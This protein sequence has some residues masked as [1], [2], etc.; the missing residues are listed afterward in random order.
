MKRPLLPVLLS[1]LVFPGAGQLYL[2]RV[3]RALLFIVPTV[4]AV[5]ILMGRVVDTANK[6]ADQIV[7]G[8]IPLDVTAIAAEVTRL[9][10]VSTPATNLACLVVLV[11]W[12]G[13]AIDA[14]RLGRS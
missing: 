8:K 9:G 14:W 10:T 2:K 12:I 6:V 11:C 3:P 5:A 7:A 4:I 13:S 1:G